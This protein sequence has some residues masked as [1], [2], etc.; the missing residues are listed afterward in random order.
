MQNMK[1]ILRKAFS[2]KVEFLLV[3][4]LK[5]FH[6]PRPKSTAAKA[7]R[8][9]FEINNGCQLVSRKIMNVA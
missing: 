8:Q 3:Y 7:L 5:S 2:L 4:F 6:L 1:N 9:L